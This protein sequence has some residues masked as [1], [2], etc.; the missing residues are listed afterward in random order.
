MEETVSQIYCNIVQYLSFLPS[1]LLSAIPGVTARASLS[2]L[3]SPIS[4]RSP[5][6]L[7]DVRAASLP[8]ARVS[9]P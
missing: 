3:I 8:A 4:R 2:R 6:D 5:D 1:L 7:A 9:D